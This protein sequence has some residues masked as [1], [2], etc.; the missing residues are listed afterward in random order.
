MWVYFYTQVN[1]IFNIDMNYQ[2]LL[3]KGMLFNLHMDDKYFLN[4]NSRILFNLDMNYQYYLLFDL[5]NE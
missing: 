1:M 4:T 2:V 5:D 3:Y